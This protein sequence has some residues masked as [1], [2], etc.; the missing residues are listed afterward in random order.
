MR[1]APGLPPLTAVKEEEEPHPLR[2]IRP[3][4]PVEPRTR[5]PQV[6][7]RF[8]QK[9]RNE[10][11]SVGPIFGRLEKRAIDYRRR[12]CRRLK[13]GHAFLDTRSDEERR[14][15]QRRDNDIA[16]TLDEEG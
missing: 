14:K 9:A 15:R 7:Q 1:Y 4:R 6:I 8:R 5:V 11:R 12:A 2:A 10:G 16:T 3:V 13:H